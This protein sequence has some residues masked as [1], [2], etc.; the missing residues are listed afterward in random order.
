MA[1]LARIN[2][3]QSAWLLTCAANS[4][5]LFSELH[6][7]ECYEVRQSRTSGFTRLTR[8]LCRRT[9]PSYFILHSAMS[10]SIKV[11]QTLFHQRPGFGKSV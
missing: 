10:E 3:R 7:D 9:R 6:L 2:G 8:E 5:A 4:P 11:Q 1:R